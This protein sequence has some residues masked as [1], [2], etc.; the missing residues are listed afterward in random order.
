MWF[1][2]SSARMGRPNAHRGMIFGFAAIG[3]AVLGIY[4][5]GPAAGQPAHGIAM[6]GEPELPADFAAYPHANPDA[7]KGG[8]MTFANLGSFDSLNPFIVKGRAPS[9]VRGNVFENLLDRNYSEPFTMYARIAKSIE[10]PDD[11]SWATFRLNPA[12]YFSDGKP[13]RADDVVFSWE[14]LKT[15]GRPNHRS[16]YSKVA[17]VETPDD[18]TVKFIFGPD[19][20][21]E[22]PLILALMPIL[23]KHIYEARDFEASSLET[24]I[25]SGPYTVGE[26]KPG[27]SITFKRDPKWWGADLPINRGRYNFDELVYEYYRDSG[28]RNVAFTKGLFDFQQEWDPTAWSTGYDFPAVRDGRVVL[29]TFER[30]TPTG[31]LALAFNT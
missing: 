7:P 1:K 30:K 25:G 23:P 26:V 10:T 28:T 12:A 11:R 17:R 2:R 5:A 9:S 8:R 21:R 6:L 20:D 29:E 4:S 18:L 24:P 14:T 16:A 13:I 19:G 15:K 31:L 22:L 3:A 27:K